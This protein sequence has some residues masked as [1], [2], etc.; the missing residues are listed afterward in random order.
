MKLLCL[1]LYIYICL[2]IY[3]NSLFSKIMFFIVLA[4]FI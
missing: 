3:L 1:K 4:E 2:C